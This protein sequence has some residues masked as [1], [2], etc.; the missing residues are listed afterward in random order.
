MSDHWD[1]L[2][3]LLD[4]GWPGEL[5][6]DAAAA[7]RTL[8]AGVPQEHVIDG[9]RRLLH[10]GARFRPSAAELLGEA[11]ADRSAP[12]F[13][14]ALRL[15]FGPG[16]VMDARPPAPRVDHAALLAAWED[17]ADW[18]DAPVGA[19]ITR[20]GEYRSRRQEAREQRA[21]QVHPLVASFVVR[22][23]YDRL[24]RDGG[25]LD[26]NPRDGRGEDTAHW[27]R[28]ELREAWDAHLEAME[29]R[30]VAVLAAGTGREGLRRVDPL[31]ALNAPAHLRVLEPGEA[32]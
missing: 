28:K 6:Q 22:L 7:Y 18:P 16:G 17:G 27:V 11:R 31:A 32:A 14:E 5:T 12:T 20:D 3:D 8:L 1:M 23:G 13:D 4:T 9:L 24:D 10:K 25:V 26:G 21:A 30:E 2:F 15:I 29:G 19:G